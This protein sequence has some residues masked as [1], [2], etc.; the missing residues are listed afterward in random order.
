MSFSYT[1]LGASG[2]SGGEIVRLAGCLGATL[3]AASGE[4]RAGEPLG[5][6]APHLRRMGDELLSTEDAVA[7]PA[8]V[9]FSCL[10][11]EALHKHLDRAAADLV[12][13]LAADF[14]FAPEW[15]YGLSEWVREE[16]VAAPRI[17]NPGCYPTAAL[18]CLLP[19]ARAGLIEGP[20]IVDALSGISGAGRRLEDRLLFAT[21][22]AGAVAYGTTGHRHVDE[23]ERG[24]A[25]FG[26]RELSV[27]FTPH[28]VPMARGLL[29]TA[30]ARL[31]AAMSD[32][33]AIAVLHDAYAGE[34]Y[35]RADEHW[36]ATKDTG[37]S[38][39]AHVSAR[40]D[41]RN[42][43]LIA[44][45]AIDNLGKGAAGQ[46]VQNA[47]ISLGIDDAALPVDGVWP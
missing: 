44:S 15:V 18:L 13:D 10:P 23:M 28:L 43:L 11:S 41:A 25:R 39:S 47:C 12:V 14:R 26:G 22:S 6:V 1:V 32:G 38:N 35:V 5:D 45:A 24:L 29:V 4:S 7:I 16:L 36:P 17:A 42:N 20:V 40:V 30:R 2:F 33:A 3:E 37:G 21:A 19:F 34:R 27:S 8:D 46:A 31:T 9:C